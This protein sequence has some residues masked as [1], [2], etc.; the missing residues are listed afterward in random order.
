MEAASTAAPAAVPQHIRALEHANRVRLARAAL[1]RAV[2]AGDLRAEQVV[3]TCPWEAE[4]MTVSELLRS[5]SRWG[6]TRT[7]KFLVPLAVN[8]NRRLGRLTLRQREALA[9]ALEEKQAGRR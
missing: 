4:T 7:R 2:R 3:R 6:R 9:T 1:K 5:Q 8:E